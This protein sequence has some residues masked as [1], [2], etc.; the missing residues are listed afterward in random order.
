MYIICMSEKVQ[1]KVYVD[2]RIMKQLW[3][4]IKRKYP[5]S[6]YGALSTEVQNAI[7][8]WIEQHN[9]TLHTESVNPSYPKSHQYASEIIQYLKSKGY[10]NQVDAKALRDAIIRFRG[11]DPRTIKK[12][13]KF[14]LDN[15]FIK[16]LNIYVYEIL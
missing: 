8:S 2:K 4:L 6:T 1:L 9:T 3:D 7:V 16:R 13:I 15:G 14:M 12:W 10:L 11:S 5:D